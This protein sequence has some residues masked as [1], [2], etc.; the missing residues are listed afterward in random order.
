MQPNQALARSGYIIRQ[1]STTMFGL[2]LVMT[3][4]IVG[5]TFTPLA[6]TPPGPGASLAWTSDDPVVVK[7]RKL[8][9]SGLLSEAE[10]V[11][12]SGGTAPAA[13]SA[14]ATARAETAEIIRRLRR[15]Y[16]LTL[17]GLVAKLKKS[18][19]DVTGADV[20][21]WR[22][23]GGVQFR[24]FDGKVCYFVREP[25]NIF[26]F[27]LEARR[28]RDQHAPAT[29]SAAPGE[30]T[31]EQRLHAHLRQV[32]DIAGRTGKTEVVPIK[33][34][35]RYRLT[36]L[37]DRPG[38]KSGSLLRCWLPFPQDYRRQRD[39]KLIRTAPAEHT[40]APNAVDGPVIGGAPQRTVYLEQRIDD[41]ARPVTFEEEFEYLSYAYYPDLADE[42]ARPQAGSVDPVYL[43]ERPPHIVFTPE[44]KATLSRV[45]GDRTNPLAKARRIFQFIDGEIR[46]C[47]EMEYAVIPSFSRK[48]LQ[49]RSGDCGVQAMLFITMCRGAGIPARWQSGW[50]SKPGDWNM[51]DWVEFYVEPWG[52]LPA[53]PSYGLQKSEDPDIRDFYF[54][55]QDAYRMVVNLDYGA[56]LQPEKKSLR[57]EPADFQRGEVE[58]DGRNLY[59]DEWTYDITFDLQPVD[60]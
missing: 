7:A 44:L 54:G 40:I 48:C 9:E 41:P 27:C 32:I 42:Q 34:R 5:T 59:F 18:I 43:A 51:H 11:L 3:A 19:P 2:G 46:Y 39:V 23:A 57:S 37:P 60:E 24:R 53:D 30:P 20:E 17:E 10:S 29:T 55:H 47:A 28:R 58:L 15:E 50:E 4:T 31:A 35:I 13:D 26:R 56:S 12:D 36:V 49:T 45:I 33:H 22:L 52:W 14:A 6:N 8:I 25:S 16:S 21:R 1:E 38:A